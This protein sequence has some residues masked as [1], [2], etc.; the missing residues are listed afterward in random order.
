MMYF[1]TMPYP[2][3]YFALVI[4]LWSCLVLENTLAGPQV[5]CYVS[6]KLLKLVLRDF[7][8]LMISSFLDRKQSMPSPKEQRVSGQ[9]EG[10]VDGE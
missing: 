4:S 3:S 7:K 5:K 8:K 1:S 10:E 2:S 9:R 6:Q